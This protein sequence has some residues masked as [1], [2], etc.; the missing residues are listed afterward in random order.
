V[1]L[2]PIAMSMLATLQP[3]EGPP[4][5]VPIVPPERDCRPAEDPDE[6]VVCGDSSENSPYRIP[7][8]FRDQRSDN[9]A[10]ASWDAR[11]RDQEA[12]ERFS[13]QADGP[14]G[15]YRQSREVDCQWRAA[16]QELRGERP[17]CGR[18]RPF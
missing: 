18:G 10:H 7:H 8:Q 3:A 11:V 4:L 5:Q 9:D 1:A 14:F 6:I 2:L 17:D 13:D 12:L 16:R 15:V